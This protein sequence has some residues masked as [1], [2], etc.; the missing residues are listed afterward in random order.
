MRLGIAVDLADQDPERIVDAAIPWATQ[1]RPGPAGTPGSRG[2]LDVLY[3][4]RP[5]IDPHPI[6]FGSAATPQIKR[7][8]EAEVEQQRR[9]EAA[10]LTELVERVPEPHRGVAR[11]LVGAPVTAL[12]D[13]GDG[14]DALM[15]ATHGRHGL[16]HFWLGSI[17]E[18]VVRHARCTVVVIRLPAV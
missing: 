12:V 14:Y 8:M 9:I 17:A 3:V 13:A 4:V 16:A 7:L 5:P 1:T 10:R 18:Q 6:G 2:T 11:L 15:V